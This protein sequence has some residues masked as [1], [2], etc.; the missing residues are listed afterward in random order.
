MIRRTR[1]VCGSDNMPG[2]IARSTGDNLFELAPRI[3]FS[4]AAAAR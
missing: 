2:S 1:G 4:A 3:R